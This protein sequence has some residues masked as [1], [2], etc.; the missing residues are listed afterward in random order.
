MKQF[1]TVK[2]H[3]GYLPKIYIP[4]YQLNYFR[5]FEERGDIVI[6]YHKIYKKP[7]QEL[8][9]IQRLLTF[10]HK[11]SK[12]INIPERQSFNIQ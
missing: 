10:H 11:Q 12:I 9:L 2:P 3:F 5:I 8:T 7:A 1:K 6:E 4:S